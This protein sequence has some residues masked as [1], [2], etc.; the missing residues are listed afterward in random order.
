M[1]KFKAGDKVKFV[2]PKEEIIGTWADDVDRDAVY[3]VEEYTE[4]YHP[5]GMRFCV[6]E[7]VM[8]KGLL[9]IF[10]PDWLE[11]VDGDSNA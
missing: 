2:M 5:F 6:G 4:N 11:L 10:H 8:L 1:A 9:Y 3:E 7:A